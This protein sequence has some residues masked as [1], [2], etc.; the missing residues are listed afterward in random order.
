MTLVGGLERGLVATA[1]LGDEALVSG[2]AEQAP[3]GA[4]AWA[5]ISLNGDR[6]QGQEGWRIGGWN[7]TPKEKLGRTPEL[8]RDRRVGPPEDALPSERT[9]SMRTALTA[10]GLV[11]ALA[12]PAAAPAGTTPTDEKNA[13]KECKAERGTDS[14]TQEAFT[15]KYGSGKNGKNAL[16]KCV[17]ERAKE[18][19][20]ERKAAKRKAKRVCQ[21]QEG[22]KNYA[23]CLTRQARKA[24][25]KQDK[26]DQEEI[27]EFKNAAKECDAER[28]EDPTTKE[29]FTTKYGTGK[30]GKN[31]FGKCVSSKVKS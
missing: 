12:F 16:G 15:L 23:K 5:P 6:S 31:A 7:A 14:A 28:G 30:K 9:Q 10:V 20:A 13:A 22:K 21:S 29:T 24:A 3:R 26:A 11:A 1:H 2:K 8:P 27:E 4:D 17:S 18:E 25:K 19:A